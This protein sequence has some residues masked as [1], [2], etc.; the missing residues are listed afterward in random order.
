M[1]LAGCEDKSI[2]IYHTV[3]GHEVCKWEGHAGLPTCLKWAPRRQLVASACSA[4]VL[5]LPSAHYLK[6]TGYIA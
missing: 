1:W 5:H 4:L 6:S 3:G 2:R